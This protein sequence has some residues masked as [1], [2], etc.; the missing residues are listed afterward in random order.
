MTPSGRTARTPASPAATC[1]LD[2]DLGVITTFSALA[3]LM[4]RAAAAL[5]VDTAR[6]AA[7]G[8]RD[9][10]QARNVY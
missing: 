6:L 10:R 1:V 2:D 4:P 8:C 5:A 7:R 3:G 9:E